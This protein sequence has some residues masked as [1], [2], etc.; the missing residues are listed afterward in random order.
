MN[1][2]YTDKNTHEKGNRTFNITLASRNDADILL[3]PAAPFMKDHLSAHL[4]A[5]ITFWLFF[6]FRLVY[7]TLA[8]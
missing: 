7:V 1:G 4:L 6:A 5:W 3:Q 2:T 8:F